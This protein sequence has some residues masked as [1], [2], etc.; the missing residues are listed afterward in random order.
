[1]V[2]SWRLQSPPTTL[3]KERFVERDCE[4]RA[5]SLSRYEL[6]GSAY[7]AKGYALLVDLYQALGDLRTATSC[8]Q[9]LVRT[10]LTLGSS[11]PGSPL[12]AMIAGRS[13]SLSRCS[14][15]LNHLFADAVRWA[16]TSGLGPGDVF[17]YYQEYE[18][19]TLARVRI[20]QGRAQEVLPLLEHLVAGAASADAKD[21]ARNGQLIAYLSLQAVA[22]QACERTDAALASL[23]RALA[24]GEPEGYVRTFGDQGAPLADLLR[25]A[26]ARGIAVDYVSRLLAAMPPQTKD[27]GRKTKDE[28]LS[29]LVEP[30]NDRE[31]QILRLLA[32]GLSNRQIAQDLYLSVNTVKWY[33]SSIY[34]KLLVNKRA[35]AVARAYELNLL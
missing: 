31:M 25:Q 11:P 33:T 14:P 35:E 34:G 27:E 30:L 2:V 13:L 20:A 4:N 28:T 32:A 8:L 3:D 19:L 10:F 23:S 21:A 15:D 29:A 6:V 12:A 9:K 16:E 26:L 24:L 5:G 1:M 17:S 7:R 18:Y 22:Y